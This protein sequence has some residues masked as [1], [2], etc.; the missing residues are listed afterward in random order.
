MGKQVRRGEGHGE[1]ERLMY[2]TELSKSH[3]FENPTCR[4][5]MALMYGSIVV[6]NGLTGYSYRGK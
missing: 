1:T 3:D 5:F 2:R 6:F 4:V